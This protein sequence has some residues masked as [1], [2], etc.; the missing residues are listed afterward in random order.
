MSFHGALLMIIFSLFY[1]S[2]KSK[3]Q[4]LMLSDYIVLFVPIGLFLGELEILL[5]PNYMA[6]QPHLLGVLYFPWWMIYQDTPRCCTRL[7]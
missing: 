1:F 2:T 3:I 6:Y 4:F 5:I 7:F